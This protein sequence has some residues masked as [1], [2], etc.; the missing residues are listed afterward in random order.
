MSA[1]PPLDI[2]V[3]YSASGKRASPKRAAPPPRPQRDPRSHRRPEGSRA[4]ATSGRTSPF[5]LLL[6]GVLNLAVAGGLYYATWWRVDRELIYMTLTYKTHVPGV[7]LDEFAKLIVPNAAP[8]P[9][10]SRGTTA[11]TRGRGSQPGAREKASGRRVGNSRRTGRTRQDARP[12]VQNPEPSAG[13]KDEPSPNATETGGA[14]QPTNAAGSDTRAGEMA[15]A[16]EQETASGDQ[17]QARYTGETAT[18]IIGISAYGWL[19][20]STIAFGFLAMAAGALLATAGGHRWRRIGLILSAGGLAGLCWFG[21]STWVQYGEAYPTG[22][23][24]WGMGGLALLAVLVGMAIGRAPK[25]LN[26]VAAAMLLVSAIG[27]VVALYL[28]HLCDAIPAEQA[29]LGFLAVVFVIHS[30]YGWL[31]LPVASRLRA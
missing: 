18:K 22:H 28:G 6:L 25:G 4:A 2:K 21:Y 5:K 8:P 16:T 10:V 7:N 26:R 29:S 24:R 15:A 9:R 30:F 12:E 3:I 1:A 17:H 14:Q 31:L 23:L 27:S 19:T 20:L 13:A 11:P